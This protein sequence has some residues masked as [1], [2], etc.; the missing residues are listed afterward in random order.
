MFCVLLLVLIFIWFLCRFII[1][2][3]VFVNFNWVCWQ[4]RVPLIRRVD[5]YVQ[6]ATNVLWVQ[7]TKSLDCVCVQLLLMSS[8]LDC[9]CVQLL[10]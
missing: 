8:V 6:V 10:L 3:H 7:F 2:F 4:C 5:F 9:V 1:D